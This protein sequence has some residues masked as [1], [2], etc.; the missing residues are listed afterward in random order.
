MA[1][2]D[3]RIELTRTG[4]FAGIRRSASVSPKAL[5]PAEAQEIKRLL[6]RLDP[7]AISRRS[8]APT[9]PDA[10]QYDI[11]IERG[12]RTERFTVRDGAIPDEVLPLIER[13][14]PRLRASSAA[15]R[16]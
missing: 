6:D 8:E 15:S 14:A 9:A 3:W 7:G 12:G 13:L 5:D 2:E 4:G 10:F 11:S 16:A 1:A